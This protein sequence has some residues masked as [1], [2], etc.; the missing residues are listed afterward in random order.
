MVNFIALISKAPISLNIYIKYSL[1]FLYPGRF[2]AEIIKLKRPSEHMMC[3]TI[4]KKWVDEIKTAIEIN[5]SPH[6]TVIPVAVYCPPTQIITQETIS[7][8]AFQLLTLGG[9]HLCTAVNE[10]LEETEEKD[11]LKD[12]SN[13][14]I[15][16]FEN[17]S[18]TEA[19]R[20][21]NLHN[22]RA[23]TT[24]LSFVDQA[25]QGRRLLYEYTNFLQTAEPPLSTPD[26]FK[27]AYQKEMGLDLVS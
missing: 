13:I 26:G 24:K 19:R 4:M 17:L 14:S 8:G 10:L 11:F 16:V 5:P 1:F 6:S 12:I 9:N 15:D 22:I 2:Q 21:G 25:R 18:T 20:L 23:E 27:V 3:R 7:N